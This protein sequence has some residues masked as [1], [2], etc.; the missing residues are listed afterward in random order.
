MIDGTGKIETFAG[1]MILAALTALALT[2]VLIIV[3]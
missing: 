2:I 1:K 3:F